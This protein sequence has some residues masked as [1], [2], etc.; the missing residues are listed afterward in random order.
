MEELPRGE[1]LQQLLKQIQQESGG[2][3]GSAVPK[4]GQEVTPQAGYVI[5]TC[6]HVRLII[7]ASYR[8]VARSFV[9]KTTDQDKRKVFI[10][11]CGSDKVPMAGGW[12]DGKVGLL[13]VCRAHAHCRKWLAWSRQHTC[14][15]H[16]ENSL[17]TAVDAGRSQKLS[18]NRSCTL[19]RVQA[20]CRELQI[21]TVPGGGKA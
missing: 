18:R 12:I 16:L 3:Q 17:T 9:V 21:P 13:F 4:G 6:H 15:N 7:A 1:K 8:C 11:I 2:T 10:N 20:R 19:R 5:C 14:K